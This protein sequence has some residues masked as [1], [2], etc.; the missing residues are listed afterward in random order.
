[1]TRRAPVLIALILVALSLTLGGVPA[2]GASGD[3]QIADQGIVVA[4]DV[5]TTWTASPNDASS[6][7][8]NLKLAARTKGCVSYVKFAK[9]NEA[10]TEAVSDD[11]A[12]AAGEQ[13]SNHSYVHKSDA[14]AGKVLGWFES[15]SVPGCLSRVFTTAIKAE[16]AKDPQA[17]K[18][19]RNVDLTLQPVDLGE[20]GF[21]TVAYEGNISIDLKDGSS[22][23]LEVGLVAVQAGR[24]LLTYSV[25]APPDATEIQTVIATALTNTVTRTVNAL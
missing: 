10:T 5:P 14:A 12:S 9:A 6:D 11:Y 20:T 7:T 23:S 19:I 13:I 16:F 15:T 1:M 4:G 18:S 2:F 25:Q 3:Q 8:K 22:Q 24:V 17:R 21:P